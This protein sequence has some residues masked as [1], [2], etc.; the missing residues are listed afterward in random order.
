MNFEIRELSDSTLH[1]FVRFPYGFFAGDP[2]WAGELIKD[3]THQLSIAHPFWLH[4]ERKLF[5]AFRDG[6]PIGRVAAII[7]RAHNSFHGDNCGFFGFFDC[8]NNTDTAKG[9]L[10]KAENWLRMRGFDNI[11]G[12]V[13]PSTNETCGV[14]INGY[15]MPAMIM[16]PYNPPYYPSILE[17]AGYAKGV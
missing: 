3:A 12:P 1:H 9:L 6:S 17:A 8:E 13:N 15:S 7:N 5:M 11:T 14:L 16:M 2:N 4:G 10:E